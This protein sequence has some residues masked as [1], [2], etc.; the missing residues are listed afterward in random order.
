MNET[1]ITV[2]NSDKSKLTPLNEKYEFI[3]NI[4]P[5]NNQKNTY[6][7]RGDKLDCILLNQIKYAST[8]IASAGAISVNAQENTSHNIMRIGKTSIDRIDNITSFMNNHIQIPKNI[9][10]D[11]I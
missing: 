10:I 7:N 3:I 9:S 2:I 6:F 5:H 11:I 8:I 4:N 1:I